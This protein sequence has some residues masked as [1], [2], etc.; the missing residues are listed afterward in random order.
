MP[1]AFGA[2]ELWGVGGFPRRRERGSEGLDSA[3]AVGLRRDPGH[4]RAPEHPQLEGGGRSQGV[5]PPGWPW[6]GGAPLCG[7]LTAGQLR[8][9]ERSSAKQSGR[10]EGSEELSG[11]ERM[12]HRHYTRGNWKLE[13]KGDKV[14]QDKKGQ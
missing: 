6:A 10:E 11:G 7:G 13:A 4:P 2:S 14:T 1:S 3:R 9:L 8:R 12:T 5:C